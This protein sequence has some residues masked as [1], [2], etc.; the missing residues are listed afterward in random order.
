L[1]PQNID[2]G[3][4]APKQRGNSEW[5]IESLNDQITWLD[6]IVDVPYV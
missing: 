2:A 6:E 1:L 3:G 5:D 4:P